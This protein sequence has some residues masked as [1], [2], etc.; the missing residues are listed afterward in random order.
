[1]GYCV[2]D[3]CTRWVSDE[4]F[5][6]F[7]L[8]DFD[9]SWDIG[10]VCVMEPDYLSLGTLDFGDYT[11]DTAAEEAGSWGVCELFILVC[12]E[13]DWSHKKERSRC[14]LNLFY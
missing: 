5:F 6:D 7:E 9:F 2:D 13:S 11:G 10:V 8:V 1:M 3:Y 4:G 12:G 14:C